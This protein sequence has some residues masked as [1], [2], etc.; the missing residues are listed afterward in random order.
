MI[1]KYIFP[2]IAALFMILSLARFSTNKIQAH[3]WMMAIIFGAVS[4]WLWV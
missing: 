4:I 3:I 2:G 1:V